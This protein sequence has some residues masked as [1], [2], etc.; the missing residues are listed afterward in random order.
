MNKGLFISWLALSFSAAS[1]IAGEAAGAS[2]ADPELRK[3]RGYFFGYTFG[4]SLRQG[5]NTDVDLDQLI[6]GLRDSLS[7]QQPRLNDTQ[8]EAVIRVIRE[9]QG[10]AQAHAQAQVDQRGAAN[11]DKAIAFLRENGARPEVTTT[12][13]GLQYEVLVEGMGA[14][15]VPSDKVSVHYEG[16]FMDG[17]PFESSVERGEPAEF[18]LSQVIAGWTEGLQTMKVGGKTRFYIHPELGYGPGGR[19]GIPPNALLIFDV[20]LL[21]IK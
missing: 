1:A 4:G 13:S 14:S 10:A 9:R 18:G 21:A 2:D 20:Q 6:Q 19:G 5:A 17:T 11:L 7:G 3:D 16:S 15:P 8:Q 12:S